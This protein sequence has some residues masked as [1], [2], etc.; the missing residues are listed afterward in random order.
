[1]RCPKGIIPPSNSKTGYEYQNEDSDKKHELY[2]RGEVESLRNP[3]DYPHE[4]DRE[5]K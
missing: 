4:A 2:S 3:I 1:M 5:E